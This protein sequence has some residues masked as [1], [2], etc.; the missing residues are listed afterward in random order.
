MDIIAE[1]QKRIIFL[2]GAMGT[3]LQSRG[4]LP[5]EL[6]ERWNIERQDD[7]VNIHMEYINAG[8]DIINTN[9]FGGN[10]FKLKEYGLE[11]K[12]D[13]INRKGVEAALIARERAKKDVWISASIGPTGK[14]LITDNVSFEEMY[15]VYYKQIK[16]CLDADIINFETATD[17]AE[18]RI[19]VLA[20]KDACKKPIIANLT[21]T[22]NGRTLTGQDVITGFNI[23]EGLGVDFVGT[24]CG[25]GPD[26]MANILRGVNDVIE[27]RIAVQANAGIPKLIDGK[28]VFTCAPDEYVDYLRPIVEAGVN[29]V[30]GCCGTTPTYIKK[31]VERYKDYRPKQVLTKNIIKLSSTTKTVIISRENEF[32]KIGE[33]INPS[34][35]KKV[36]DDIRAKSTTNIKEIARQQ[37]ENG[38]MVLDINLGL[39]GTNEK[40][41]FERVIP[42]ISSSTTLPLVIDTTDKHALESALRLYPGRALINSVSGEEERLSYVLPL[43]KRYGAYSILLPLDENGIPDNVEARM[44]IIETVLSEAKKHGIEK[45]RFIVDVLVMTVSAAPDFIGLSIRTAIE[46]Y[47]RFGL[48][49]IAGL[50]NVSFG[51]PARPSINSSFLAMLMGAG[52]DAAILNPQD[53]LLNITI[54]ASNVLTGRDKNG[55]NYIKKYQGI[56]DFFDNKEV[57]KEKVSNIELRVSGEIK[58][59]IYNSIVTG[60]KDEVLRLLRDNIDKYDSQDIVNNLLIP[61]INYVGDLYEKKVYFL[62]QLIMSADAMKSAMKFLEPYLAKGTTQKR[63]TIILATVKGDIHDIGK[64]IV[65]IMLSNYGFNVIDLG[66]DVSK[67]TILDAAIRE[68]A[69]II[70]LSA[71]MTTTMIEMENFINYMKDKNVDL[72]VMVGGAVLNKE[73]ADKIGAYYS[74]DGAEA[75]KVALGIMDKRKS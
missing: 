30:G 47:K 44:R 71:L 29:I 3:M 36:A 9:T 49:S 52:L 22:D 45:N 46:S 34:A 21:F 54:D 17:I 40:E 57:I 19:A 68:K 67:E 50:S 75:V 51:L 33:K 27:A 28:T 23:L 53:K 10:F 12:V 70:G 39:G 56:K 32:C 18:L 6:P 2:D 20:A 55:I 37:E 65:A 1:S 48:L 60:N 69:D 73:Y 72:P 59:L 13:L 5:G 16:A 42:E 24:N 63:G 35:L 43:M 64:N 11:E 61:A 74:K 58:D 26:D 7:I 62:P 15:D 31:I 8:A 38:A 14:V 66:K 4:L 25:M 41:S